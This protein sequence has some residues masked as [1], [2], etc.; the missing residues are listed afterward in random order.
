MPLGETKGGTPDS[1]HLAP[2]LL[3]KI[4]VRDL[5]TAPG[6]LIEEYVSQ[7]TFGYE[8]AYGTLDRVNFRPRYFGK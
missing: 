2:V 6:S 5:N 1:L 8:S 4:P 3:V 7:E